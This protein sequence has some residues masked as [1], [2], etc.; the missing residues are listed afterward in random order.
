[1]SSVCCAGLYLASGGQ[2]KKLV[3]WEME[4]KEVLAQKDLDS[5]PG[6]LTWHSGEKGNTLASIGEDGV[7]HLWHSVIPSHML[8]PT[9]PLDDALPKLAHSKEMSEGTGYSSCFL[10]AECCVTSITRPWSRLEYDN[11]GSFSVQRQSMRQGME[12][13]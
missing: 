6:A 7:I 1:M 2:D 11:T 12:A 13:A 8:T 5:M 3:V 4:K 9:A 10:I